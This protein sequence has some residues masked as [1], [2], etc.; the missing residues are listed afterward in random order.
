MAVIGWG[1][2]DLHAGTCWLPVEHCANLSVPW[3]R[4]AFHWA[5]S[6]YR[7]VFRSP[8][9][10]W[11]VDWIALCSIQTRRFQRRCTQSRSCRKLLPSQTVSEVVCMRV[12]KCAA[13]IGAWRIC[14]CCL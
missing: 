11:V 3:W 2:F 9:C 7:A 12:R 4:Y 10:G 5:P 8:S 13:V 6:S 1:L 14:S